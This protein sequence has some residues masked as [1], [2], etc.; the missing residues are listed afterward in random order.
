MCAC[1]HA[2]AHTPLHG[3]A[4][5][6]ETQRQGPGLESGGWSR[7][8]NHL[9]SWR[10]RLTLPSLLLASAG[11]AGTTAPGRLVA[12]SSLAPSGGM[13]R[14][15]SH[16]APSA[17]AAGLSYRFDRVVVG[18]V[19]P[20]LSWFWPCLRSVFGVSMLRHSAV[21]SLYSLPLLLSPLFPAQP[22]VGLGH[23]AARSHCLAPAQAAARRAESSVCMVCP[24]PFSLQFTLL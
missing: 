1:M 19:R 4:S 8:P 9:L 13:T 16:P 10:M 12:K 22:S 7:C 21:P 23:E 3:P 6:S 18:R 14:G 20:A 11:G 15:G 5:G 2:C 24:Y 17:S